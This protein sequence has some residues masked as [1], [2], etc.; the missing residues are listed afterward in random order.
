MVNYQKG[1]IYKLQCND[2]HFYI[3]STCN[4]LRIRLGCHKTLSKTRL[5][6]KVYKHIN[7]VG[8]DS[9]SIILVENVPCE[10]KE[11]LKKKEDEFLMKELNNELCLNCNRACKTQQKDTRDR[12]EYREQNK[13]YIAARA[14]AYRE[15]HKERIKAREKAYRE[16]NKEVIKERQR[17]Y[18]E[19]VKNGG[20]IQAKV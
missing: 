11:E 6:M 16:A 13:E 14:K 7:S 2:G 10:S 1:K 19:K 4:E 5:E 18:L 12:R 17:R 9:V 20:D 8:W 3:G 15:K